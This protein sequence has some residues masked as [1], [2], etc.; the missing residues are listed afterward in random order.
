MNM[1]NTCTEA[2]KIN[3]FIA[4]HVMGWKTDGEYWIESS[5]DE[6]EGPVY[7]VYPLSEENMFR[8]G[9]P[10]FNPYY[11]ANDALLALEVWGEPV[12]ISRYYD[13]RWVLYC[14]GRV[15]SG[16]T[17]SYIICMVLVYEYSSKLGIAN[18]LTS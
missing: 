13:G 8:L 17:L 15:I 9:L 7:S 14:N 6:G 3:K 11:D 18:P 1:D 12:A 2:E 4:K 10:Q 16:H 5:G